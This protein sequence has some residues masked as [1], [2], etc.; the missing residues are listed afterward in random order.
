MIGAC[1]ERNAAEKGF[2]YIKSHLK[3][4]FSRSERGTRAM[5]FLALLG[6]ILSAVIAATCR[7][8]YGGLKIIS[9]IR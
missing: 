5:L 1:R 2:L 6:Y 4:L 8:K 9:G 7:I 3:S